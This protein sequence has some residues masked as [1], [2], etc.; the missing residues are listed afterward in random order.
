MKLY[1]P[2]T[3]NLLNGFC[4]VLPLLGFRYGIPALLR[5]DALQEL[6]Y[7]PPVQN[8]EKL[9]LKAYFITNTF[10]VFSPL[11][12]RIQEHS[13][14]AAFGWGFFALGMVFLVLSLNQYSHNPGLK[15]KGIY[16][17]SRNPMILG[18]FLIYIGVPL[19]IGSWFHLL[20]TILY[21]IAVHGLILSEERW[22]CATFGKPYTQYM[23][24]VRRYF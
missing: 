3:L 15:T 18:Y 17:F 14:N 11:L 22:C 19:V 2:L 4:L 21:Q 6:A 16:H 8:R 20:I 7:F 12:A 13:L 10:L 24:S 5:K 1:P 9:A 23:Q